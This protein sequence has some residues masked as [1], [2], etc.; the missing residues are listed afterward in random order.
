[1]RDPYTVLGV[2]KTASE[3]EIKSAFRKLAKRYHPDRNKDDPK[4]K[5]Q[6]AEVNNAYEIL[7]DKDKKGKFDR[8]EI[9]AA[10]KPRGFE[11]F[12]GGGAGGGGPFGG[13]SPFG[14]AEGFSF[15]FG[16]G[17][18]SGATQDIP[19]DVLADL[20]RGFGGGM[21][22]NMGG[23]RG[24]RQARSHAAAAGRDVAG[25]V[26]ISLEELAQGTTKRVGLPD[27]KTVEVKIPAWIG[28]GKV[29]RLAGQ[30]EPSP[31]GGKP[32]DV[33]LT[34]RHAPHPRF[35]VEG[36]NLRV[37][38]PLALAD[39]VLG[40]PIRV[41]TLTGE[42][43]MNVPAGTSGGRSFRLRGQGLQVDGT[44]GDILVSV[45]IQIPDD[46]ELA[47]LMRKRRG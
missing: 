41:P 31:M 11:G 2:Q 17:G 45:D 36:G 1:M 43:E 35:A 30:G 37:R 23:G 15:N 44:R 29:M 38:V 47:A 6:F 12:P 26:T 42:V 5:D 4:A 18:R 46:P 7:G 39:A 3:A 28:D 21:G 14:G 9:D 16:R 27:G 25:D 19:E 24:G 33:L 10:G 8:G 20:L 22:G 40:G 13:G 32:G 34:I